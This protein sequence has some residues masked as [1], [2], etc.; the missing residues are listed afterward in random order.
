[1]FP[2]T[3]SVPLAFSAAAAASP[4]PIFALIERHR[5]LWDEWGEALEAMSR[6]QEACYAQQGGI[7]RLPS[8]DHPAIEPYHVAVEAVGHAVH[9]CLC[10]LAQTPPTTLAG[11]AAVLAYAREYQEATDRD[12]LFV[13]AVI[14]G[15][16]YS[17]ETWIESLETAVGALARA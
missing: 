5:R 14:S 4:D 13:S 7:G 12:P 15:P 6:A 8:E 17:V 2:N 9:E 16:A 10:E 11:L 3:T 1:V